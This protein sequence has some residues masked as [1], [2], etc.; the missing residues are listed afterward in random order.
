MKTETSTITINGSQTIGPVHRRLFGGFVEHMGRGVYGGV[1]DPEHPAADGEGYREDVIELVKELGMTVFR[2]PGGNFVS[3][4]KWEDGIGPKESRPR[5]L[6]LPWHSVE[7]NAFGLHEFVRWVE[8]VDGEVMLATNLGTRGILESLDL[9]EYCNVPGGTDW[10]ELRRK[11]GSDKPFNIR[12]WCLGNELDGPW[13]LGAMT[14]DQ[15]G[16]LAARTAKAMRRIDP[17]LE[18]VACGSSGFWMPTFGEWERTVLRHT[19]DDVDYISCHAYFEPKNGDMASYL[20]S[21]ARMDTYILDLIR[22]ADGVRDELGSKKTMQLSFDEWNIWYHS[23][24]AAVFPTGMDNWPEAPT[25]TEDDY[26]IADGVV[27]GDLLITLL[28]HA[29]RI[30]TAC[31]AQVVNVI[32]P[33]SAP[34]DGPAWRKT[35][36]YPFSLTSRHAR[37][38]G[39]LTTIEAPT[40]HTDEHGDVAAVSAAVVRSEEGGL[41]IFVANRSLES[42]IDATID[43]SQLSQLSEILEATTL[44]GPD[45]NVLNTKEDPMRV[46]PQPNSSA[47][48]DGATLKITLPAVSW[49]MIRLQ[50]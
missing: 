5:R 30:T 42:Q 3:G 24:M 44:G 31:M 19:Y 49:S 39:L 35:T 21:A 6:N 37:G 45:Y 26:S 9:L 16:S 33:I 10:S 25:I 17:D 28:N 32:A 15:Y 46:L 14:A 18:L 12:M 8:K 11:N 36:F 29:D 48:L 23:R 22:D 41:V 27:V 20:A 47:K 34:S 4:F 1:Y 2:Y 40:I 38:E 13:Q 43:L 50:A 7:T